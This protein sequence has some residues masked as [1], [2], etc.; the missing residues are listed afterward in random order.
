MGC[1]L[2]LSFFSFLGAHQLLSDCERQA[3]GDS[4]SYP[5]APTLVGSS[6]KMFRS[7]QVIDSKLGDAS[8]CATPSDK[9]RK[10]LFLDVEAYRR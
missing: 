9:A 3:R 6:D 1:N 8:R 2:S 7:D 5:Y 4:D 10:L